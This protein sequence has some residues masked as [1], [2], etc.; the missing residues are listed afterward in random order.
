M[1]YLQQLLKERSEKLKHEF[2]IK[3]KERKKS[4]KE[5]HELV[6]HASNIFKKSFVKSKSE[7][8]REREDSDSE[9]DEE[10]EHPLNKTRIKTKKYHIPEPHA[11]KVEDIKNFINNI[12]Y[13]HIKNEHKKYTDYLNSIN[14]IHGLKSQIK[15]HNKYNKK[16]YLDIIPKLDVKHSEFTE[17]INLLNQ[18]L[19]K[20]SHT[21]EIQNAIK[22]IKKFK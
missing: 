1:S 9:S 14:K 16:K 13:A 15:K 6:K 7:S 11:Q 4:Q 2:P 12:N 8:E 22:Y 10:K 17:V 21:K 19:E 5:Q 18:A 20:G 3:E